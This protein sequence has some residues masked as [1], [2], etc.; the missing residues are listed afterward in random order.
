M[1]SM[2]SRCSLVHDKHEPAP[3]IDGLRVGQDQVALGQPLHETFVGG[4][5][6]VKGRAVLDL[7]GKVAAGTEDEVDGLPGLRRVGAA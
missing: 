1:A 7:R 4:G 5:E 3:C 6:D 2:S